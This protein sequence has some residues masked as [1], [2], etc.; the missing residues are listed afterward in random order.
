MSRH[1]RLAPALLKGL[2][3]T[4]SA[5]VLS[6]LATMSVAQQNLVDLTPVEPGYAAVTAA[7]QMFEPNPPPGGPVD[8]PVFMLIDVRDPAGQGAIAD[9]DWNAPKDI[10]DHPGSVAWYSS[11]FMDNEVFGIAVTRDTPPDIFVAS[12]GIYGMGSATGRIFR[13]HAGPAVGDPW[14]VQPWIELPFSAGLG[15]G[16]IAYDIENDQLFA[17]NF[18]DG[19]IY[20]ISANVPDTLLSTYDPF[21]DDD[22]VTGF[23]PKRERIW[24][25]GVWCGAVYFGT[26]R[27]D[28]QTNCGGCADPHNGVYEVRL[29][30]GGEFTGTPSGTPAGVPNF[31]DA[32]EPRVVS[33][34]TNPPQMGGKNS[35]IA[36]VEFNSQGD[37]LVGERTMASDAGSGA[38]FSG[39]YEYLHDSPGTGWDPAQIFIGVGR[40]YFGSICHGEMNASGGID[41]AECVPNGAGPNFILANGDALHVQDACAGPPPPDDGRHGDALYGLQVTPMLPALRHRDFSFLVDFDERTATYRT[42][43][44]GIGDVDYVRS[45]PCAVTGNCCCLE[46]TPPVMAACY[47]DL[48]SAEAAALLG[49]IATDACSNTAPVKGLVLPSTFDPATCVATITVR[50]ADSCGN[51]EFVVVSAKVDGDAP[52]LTGVPADIV[53]E[54]GDPVPGPPLVTASDVCDGV[55]PVGFA[56][57]TEG[58]CPVVIT[59]KWF[60]TDA[61][62]NFVGET[63]TV[64][65]VDTLPPVLTGVPGNIEIECGVAVPAPPVVTAFDRCSGIVPVIFTTSTAD[66]ICPI[67]EVITRTWTATDAC[68]LS[69]SETRTVTIRDTTPP[70]VEPQPGVCLWPPNHWYVCFDK[71]DFPGAVVDACPGTVS[72]AFTGCSSDQCDEAPCPGHPGE[73]GDGNTINDCVIGPTGQWVCMRAERAGTDPEGRHYGVVV[74]AT[75]ECGN[76]VTVPFMTVYVPHDQHPHEDCL[77][78]TQVGCKFDQNIPNCPD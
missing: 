33:T 75:D 34:P 46:V 11:A 27:E 22:G 40:W 31:V 65:I 54:C 71:A 62:G 23:C 47:P 35:P 45:V 55:L 41:Y 78:T 74:S 60:A 7:S 26:W 20:R 14:V 76:S 17:T 58:T 19:R 21:G 4:V 67:V 1:A 73:N 36:D 37:M 6:G 66:G 50:V 12:T 49:T 29:Q 16:N 57:L 30:P 3:S 39:A 42:A 77:K 52:V 43:K 2:R 44:G 68:G 8:S 53:I 72:W 59:R 15:L 70:V 38:H 61:C 28:Q 13:V 63:R 25:I 56:E 9:T 5:L 64:T 48:A 18:G 32:A 10:N 24:G 51:V 69:V